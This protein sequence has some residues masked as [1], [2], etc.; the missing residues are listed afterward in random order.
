MSWKLDVEVIVNGGQTGVERG[1]LEAARVCGVRT[2]GWAPFGWRTTAGN[3]QEALSGLGLIDMEVNNRSLRLQRN[4]TS[5]GLTIVLAK[6]FEQSGV[7]E[8]LRAAA[9]VEIG[10]AHV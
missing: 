2:A 5:V 8:A 4:A 7:R 10:R 1:A 9:Q 6:H 3:E